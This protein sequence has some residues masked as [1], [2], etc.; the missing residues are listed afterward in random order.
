[1][2]LLLLTQFLELFLSPVI[3]NDGRNVGDIGDEQETNRPKSE[4]SEQLLGLWV[5]LGQE[6]LDAKTV[7]K[8]EDFVCDFNVPSALLLKHAAVGQ[9]VNRVAD[10]QEDVHHHL[11]VWLFE[12]KD[13][14]DDENLASHQKDEGVVPD[15]FLLAFSFRL[16]CETLVKVADAVVGGALAQLTSPLTKYADEQKGEL[17]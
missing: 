4:V 6:E 16:Q 8:Q 9:Q 2:H 15:G 11:H 12:Q 1:M 13:G 5:W 14:A 17:C 7:E 3:S 10:G